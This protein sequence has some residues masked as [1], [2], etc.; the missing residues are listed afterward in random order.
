MEALPPAIESLDE[1]GRLVVAWLTAPI[2]D[3]ETGSRP[4]LAVYAKQHGYAKKTLYAAKHDPKVLEAASE[5]LKRSLSVDA[6]PTLWGIVLER[7][8]QDPRFALRV[9][10]FLKECGVDPLAIGKVKEPKESRE[11]DERP[12]TIEEMVLAIRRA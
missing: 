3:P 9:L 4:P 1:P 10:E 2:I 7:A 6:V 8:T 12:G 11:R 5:L